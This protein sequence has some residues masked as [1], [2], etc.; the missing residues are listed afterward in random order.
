MGSYDYDSTGATFNYFLLSFLAL[1]LIPWTASFLFGPR[2]PA[3]HLG[4][5]SCIPCQKKRALVRKQEKKSH[6]V[7]SANTILFV[8]AWLLFGYV[9]YTLFT[10]QYADQKRWDPYE[11]LGVST[12]STSSAIKKAYRDLGRVYHPDKAPIGKEDEYEKL[13]IDMTKAH[14]VLTDKEAREIFDE[15]GH[16]DGKQAFS[17]GIALPQWLVKE[18]NTSWV[19]GAYALVFMGALPYFVYQWWNGAKHMTKDKILNDT[20]ARY[21]REL[22][23]VLPAKSVI[24]LLCIAEEF[25]SLSLDATPAYTQLEEK[26]RQTMAAHGDPFARVKR[27][28]NIAPWCQRASVLLIAYLY[29]I[30]ITDAALLKQQTEVVE[31]VPHLLTGL[32]QLSV[33]RNW[34]ASSLAIIELGQGVIQAQMPAE[35][36]AALLQL[37]HLDSEQL[38]H[39]TTKK[40]DIR[41]IRQLLCLEES[42]RRDLLRSLSDDQYKELMTVSLQYP[43]LQITK[44]GFKVVGEDRVTPGSLVTLFVELNLLDLEGLQLEKKTGP[45]IS[46]DVSEE[47]E[48][49]VKKEWWASQTS[50]V[51]SVH[52]PYFPADKKPVWWVIMG[53]A[54]HNRLI[55]MAKVTD[56]SLTN[57]G[58]ARLQFQAPPRAGSMTFTIQVKSDSYIGCDGTI[59]ITLHVSED[60]EEEEIEDDISEPDE[61][62]IAGQMQQLKKGPSAG[63]NNAPKEPKGEFDDSSDEEDDEPPATINHGHGHQHGPGCSH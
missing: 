47:D 59:E 54:K 25:S 45:I 20:M 6:P 62:S 19:L 33:A 2:T 40:R 24:E 55:C 31:Q 35:P 44:A 34:L 14:K 10:T 56:L 49:E 50:Q 12:D 1:I 30:E 51:E 29:H 46:T 7:L 15:W 5:C 41:F 38:K 22:K 23:E 61:D 32:L 39:F 27:Y 17:A 13:W 11:I 36:N 8:L 53:D 37:P 48:A 3:N 57:P 16:P 28:N 9:A 21:F 60:A 43:Q 4:S 63:S 42:E 26:V 58:K 18:G 52:A